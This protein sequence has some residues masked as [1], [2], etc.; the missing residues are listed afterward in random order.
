M[1]LGLA[2]GAVAAAAL[3]T[4]AGS[5]AV[6]PTS[7]VA[8][9]GMTVEVLAKNAWIDTGFPRPRGSDRFLHV[10]AKGKWAYRPDKEYEV[11]PSGGNLASSYARVDGQV[12]YPYHAKGAVKGALIG[13]WGKD[14]ETFFVGERYTER[15]QDND[16]LR[17]RTLYLGIND[18]QFDNNAGS[19]TVLVGDMQR[20]K[21]CGP[22]TSH[23]F[24]PKQGWV[25]D[26]C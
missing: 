25:A 2:V 14:G 3:P 16:P 9:A 19:L 23:H 22:V 26:R 6:V 21:D 1:L 4:P 15:G 13:K 10:E 24:D 8:K 20:I 12:S 17:G 5:P 11:G 7:A 18:D